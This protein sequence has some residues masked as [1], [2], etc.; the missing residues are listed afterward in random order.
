[1]LIE[2]DLGKQSRSMSTLMQPNENE[3][4]GTFRGV[5]DGSKR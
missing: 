2:K 4:K 1:M 5:K 3:I